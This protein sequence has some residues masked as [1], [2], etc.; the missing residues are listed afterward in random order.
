M[1]SAVVLLELAAA[2]LIAVQSIQRINR[3]SRCTSL[4][5]FLSWVLLGGSAAAVAGSVLSGTASHDAYTTMVISAAA[6]VLAL[7]RRM[8]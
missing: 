2:L 4:V 7:D 6:A 1:T 5:W 3:M 8:R